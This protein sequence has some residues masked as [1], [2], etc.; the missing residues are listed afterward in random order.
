M[1]E[2]FWLRAERPSR[3]RQLRSARCLS[4]LP[5]PAK[6]FSFLA[7]VIRPRITHCRVSARRALGRPA[8]KLLTLALFIALPMSFGYWGE[9]YA[10]QD[11]AIMLWHVIAIMHFWYDGFIW[12]VRKKQV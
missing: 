2:G 11:K 8:G 10:N 7:G 4:R 3:Y 6:N 12:S 1:E 9:A 5:T